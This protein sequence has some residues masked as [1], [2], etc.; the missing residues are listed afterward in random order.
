MKIY[1]NR[2]DND[3][4]EITDYLNENG[5]YPD[6]PETTCKLYK[7]YSDSHYAQWLAFNDEELEKFVNWIR[8]DYYYRHLDE[9]EII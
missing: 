3:I 8:D 4:K 2:F 7:A 6:S 1:L 9:F 5:I